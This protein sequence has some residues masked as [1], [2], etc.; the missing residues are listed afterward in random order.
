M[1]ES[2]SSLG[3]RVVVLFGHSDPDAHQGHFLAHRSFCNLVSNRQR[4]RQARSLGTQIKH[5]GV[6]AILLDYRPNCGIHGYAA[7]RYNVMPPLCGTPVQR[8]PDTR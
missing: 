8:Y 5:P 2:S 7:N 3:N 6:P 4:R 1:A